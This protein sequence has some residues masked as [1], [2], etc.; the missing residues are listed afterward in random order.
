MLVAVVKVFIGKHS[1][2]SNLLLI[3]WGVNHSTNNI[4]AGST[5][6][7]TCT[8]A[9]AFSNTSYIAVADMGEDVDTANPTQIATKTMTD[10]TIKGANRKDSNKAKVGDFNY[11]AIGK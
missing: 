6:S 11:I 3:N 10:I 2:I 1:D 8:F 4:T 7:Y 9:Y 5:Q